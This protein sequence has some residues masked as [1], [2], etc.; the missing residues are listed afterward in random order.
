M[1]IFTFFL[2]LTTYI[3]KL[4]QYSIMQYCSKNFVGS[5]TFINFAN[6]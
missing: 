2:L 3:K 1:H 6:N 5:E 4:I